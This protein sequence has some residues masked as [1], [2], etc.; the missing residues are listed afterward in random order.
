[1]KIVKVKYGKF[2]EFQAIP[3]FVYCGRGFGGFPA[4]PL[5]NPFKATQG[6]QDALERYRD[7]L[8]AKRSDRSLGTKHVRD[9][10][11]ALTEASILGCWCVDKEA[12]VLP[13]EC[14]CDI[15]AQTWQVDLAIR[16]KP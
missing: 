4:S 14:H 5:G 13:L 16:S 6:L 7:W 11:A 10:F 2:A 8:R 1:M 3:G 15:I 12:G 9:A